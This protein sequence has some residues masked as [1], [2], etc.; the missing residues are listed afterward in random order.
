MTRKSIGHVVAVVRI[1]ASEAERELYRQTYG[2]ALTSYALRRYLKRLWET[3]LDVMR[4]DLQREQDDEQTTTDQA[5][6]GER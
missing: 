1:I 2:R 6:D 3:E 5:R 4:V